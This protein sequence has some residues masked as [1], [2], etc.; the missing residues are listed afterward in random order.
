MK[1]NVY[2]TCL[3]NKWKIYL[4]FNEIKRNPT[5]S[6]I[7]KM[8]VNSIF[9]MIFSLLNVFLP[10]FICIISANLDKDGAYAA[11]GIGYVTTFQMAFSQVGFSF[12]IFSSLF[13]FKIS[14]NKNRLFATTGYDLVYDVLL[15]A[16]IYGLIITPIYVSSSYVYTKYANA[17]NNTIDSLGY[18]YD[19]IYSSSGYVFLI[20]ILYTLIMFINNKKGQ[21]YGIFYLFFCFG[22]I[23]LLSSVLGIFTDLKGIGVGLGLTI[24]VVVS[25]LITFI[26]CYFFTNTF[27]NIRFKIRKTYLGLLLDYTWRPSLTTLSIQIFKGCALLLLSFQIPDA[28]VNSVP[29]DYQMS[30][31]IW[32][33][34][35]YLVPFLLLGMVDSNYYFFMKN[36][37]ENNNNVNMHT[38]M[39]LNGFI[40]L[41]LTVILTVACNY[42]VVGL[43]NEYIKNQERTYDETVIIENLQLMGKD[44]VIDYINSSVALTDEQK[45]KLIEVVQQI[46]SGVIDPIIKETLLPKFISFSATNIQNILIFPKSFTYFYLCFYCVL[47]PLGQY[48]NGFSLAYTKEQPKT[49]LLVV[50]QGLAILFVIEFGINYQETQ[51]FYLMEA[52][53]FPLLIIGIVAIVY[54]SFMSF[55]LLDKHNKKKNKYANRTLMI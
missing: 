3:I 8:W 23:I 40:L 6:L 33:N 13:Y 43:S 30:R 17:H 5:L 38:S 25:I 46:P 2:K 20:T 18:A 55:I 12:A 45:K 4:K 34:V 11:M 36:D 53:S 16:L 37:Y 49:F 42:L 31:I 1:L 24:G 44:K 26:Q 19:F 7:K 10:I 27:Q 41:V 47:Y 28:L 48:M 52:W 21:V 39:L 35:M 54:L 15:L 32:Y 14:R 51:K 22:L 9:F 29:L 50:V